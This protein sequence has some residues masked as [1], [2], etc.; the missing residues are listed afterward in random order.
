MHLLLPLHYALTEILLHPHLNWFLLV[1]SPLWLE[2]HNEVLTGTIVESVEPG[3]SSQLA[4]ELLSQLRLFQY[5]IGISY[6]SF[7]D[8]GSLIHL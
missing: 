8:H 3:T 4:F 5:T 6:Q 2:H 7:N 1:L